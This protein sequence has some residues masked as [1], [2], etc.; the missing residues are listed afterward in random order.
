M[1]NDLFTIGHSNHAEDYFVKLVAHYHINVIVDV[2]SSPY[3]RHNPQFN[4]ECLKSTL[5][6][7]NIKYLFMGEELGARRA[8]R[9]CYKNNQVDFKCV[10]FLP[11]FQAGIERI[12]KGLNYFRIA[13]MCSEK[14]P[15][16]CHRT[17]LISRNMKWQNIHINHILSDGSLEPNNLTEKRLLDR[18]D[19][20][21][22]LFDLKFDN[23]ALLE[24]AYDLRGD[25]IAYK[26]DEITWL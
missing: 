11:I 14:E 13:L 15:L 10:S 25:E 9:E 1:L 23:R 16:D 7:N 26:E 5:A 19:I 24:K 17:I 6:A 21:P 18:F 22:L 12:R 3:S 20:Q 4:R 2:R 8:E